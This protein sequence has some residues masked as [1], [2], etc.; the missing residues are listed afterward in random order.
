M[1]GESFSAPTNTGLFSSFKP[2]L[3]AASE[4]LSDVNVW[5]RPPAALQCILWPLRVFSTILLI[6]LCPSILSREGRGADGGTDGRGR[7]P[8][9]NV[10]ILIK[11]T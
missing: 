4:K 3:T 7:C 10:T 2:L 6:F 5:R 1:T 9:L 8:A 11:Q